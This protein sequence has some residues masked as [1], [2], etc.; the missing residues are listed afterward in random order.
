MVKSIIKELEF[1]LIL[2]Q[3]EQESSLFLLNFLNYSLETKYVT[4]FVFYTLQGITYD[5]CANHTER[6]SVSSVSQIKKYVRT[7]N[8]RI[9]IGG[10]DEEFCDPEA[11]DEL[12]RKKTEILEKKFQIYCLQYLSKQKWLGV[13]L[14]VLRKTDFRSLGHGPG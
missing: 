9:I 13:E 8:N 4:T 14:L 3:E 2:F 10:E 7:C 11:R 6:D 12:L 1:F 5:L